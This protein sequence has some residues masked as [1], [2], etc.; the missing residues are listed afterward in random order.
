[1]RCCLVIILGT[2]LLLNGCASAKS[3]LQSSE[4]QGIGEYPPPPKHITRKRLAVIEF[5]D[6]TGGKRGEAGAD[7]MTTLLFK[8]RRFQII[9]RERLLDLL[10][11]QGLEGIVSPDQLAKKQQVKG[12]ELLCFGSI[13]NFEVKSTKTKNTGGVLSSLANTAA[14]YFSPIPI[15][16]IDFDYERQELEFHIGVD[17]RI[18]DTTTGEIL[19]A[20]SSDVKRTDT[21]KSLGLVIIGISTRPDGSIEV[22]NENQGKL[23][24]MAL[25]RTIKKVLPDIDYSLEANIH[26]K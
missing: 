1:M 12:V 22:D 4:I 14:N 23:L 6:K 5:K 10:K 18:L 20:E 25:D 19:F 2:T 13:T 11:E 16:N 8:T 9:E 3:E 21:A 17:I 15:P 26:Y 24:R 7:Q